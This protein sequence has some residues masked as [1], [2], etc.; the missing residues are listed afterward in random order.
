M[1]TAV[2]IIYYPLLKDIKMKYNAIL[3]TK[4]LPEPVSKGFTKY[5]ADFLIAVKNNTHAVKIEASQLKPINAE[6]GDEIIIDVTTKS[7]NGRTYYNIN[8]FTSYEKSPFPPIKH[9]YEAILDGDGR[10]E[11]SGKIFKEY[12]YREVKIC[13]TEVYYYESVDLVNPLAICPR[14]HSG[15]DFNTLHEIIEVGEEIDFTQIRNLDRCEQPLWPHRESDQEHLQEV[16][17]DYLPIEEHPH[18]ENYSATKIFQCYLETGPA[19]PEYTGYR[20]LYGSDEGHCICGHPIEDVRWIKYVSPKPDGIVKPELGA[21][22][23]CCIR[24]FAIS[25]GLYTRLLSDIVENYKSGNITTMRD[26]NKKNG[27]GDL[28]MRLL[29]RH[30]LTPDELNILEKALSNRTQ[31]PLDNAIKRILHHISE[32]YDEH[33]NYV[34]KESD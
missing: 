17:R 23:N 2:E 7:V 22:G 29:A 19:H 12:P 1:I 6:E 30:V 8:P 25:T 10:D 32:F 15:I 18:K 28:Q 14:E 11:I 33:Y 26:I 16:L 27:L 9:T 3:I 5:A 20:Y 13:A 31:R 24:H 21:I 4:Y 34:F